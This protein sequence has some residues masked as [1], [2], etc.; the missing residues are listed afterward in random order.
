MTCDFCRISLAWP[1]AAILCLGG[2][3]SSVTVTWEI[4]SGAE[5][6]HTIIGIGIGIGIGM[7]QL[8]RALCSQQLPSVKGW[9]W[10]MART[11]HWSRMGGP[12]NA[13]PPSLS[14]ET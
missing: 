1:A 9:N 6:A 5:S 12:C 3:G 4:G 10:M 13:F 11:H 2:S 8:L 7:W 14:V